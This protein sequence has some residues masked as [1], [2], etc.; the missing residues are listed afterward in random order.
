MRLS[1]LPA[2]TRREAGFTPYVWIIYLLP[3]VADPFWRGRSIG[4]IALTLVAAFVFLALYFAGYWSRGRRLLLIVAAITALG[5]V[6][7]P[8]NRGAGCFFIFA[9]G[10]AGSSG[11]PVQAARVIAAVLA[12][13]GLAAFAYR[14]PPLAWIPVIVIAAIIGAVCIQAAESARKNQRL[15]AAQEEIQRLAQVAERERIARDLH[16]L[17][18]HTLS[19]IVLKTELASKLADR[20]TAAAFREIRDVEQIARQ[21][22]REVRAAVTGYRAQI[23]EEIACARQAFAAAGVS[24]EPSVELLPLSAAQESVLAFAIREG[25]T[26]VLRHAGAR[27]CRVELHRQEGRVRLLVED[28]GRGGRAPEG[29]GLASMRERVAAL[30]GVLERFAEGGTRLVISLPLETAS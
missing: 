24:F 9:A 26:N 8:F 1:L 4:V 14:L 2:E 22:L 16:D 12:A 21:A 30:G 23:G 20:D 28:D 15:R 27:R 5:L 10:H 29:S 19:V 3:F 13:A 7:I 25:V 11:P 18:G 6:F 17:L